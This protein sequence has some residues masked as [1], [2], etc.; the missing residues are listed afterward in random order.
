MLVSYKEKGNYLFDF[1]QN[2]GEGGIFIE[3]ETPPAPGTSID[4]MF[5]LPTRAETVSA[6]GKVIWVQPPVENRLDLHPGMG[7]QFVSFADNDK[8]LLQEFLREV[9][10]SEG[11]QS[12]IDEPSS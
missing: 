7:V 5:T 8:N 11:A 6:K 1:S 9:E 10:S 12:S 4:L 3:T 2:L